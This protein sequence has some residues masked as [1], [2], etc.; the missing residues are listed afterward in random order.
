MNIFKERNTLKPYEY[1]EVMQFVDAVN[2]SYW[3]HSEVT[4]TADKQDFKV[5]LTDAEREIIQ[6]TLLAISTIEVKVKKF[7][8]NIDNYCPKPEISAVG[9]TFSESEVRHER[10][11]SELLEKL[12]LNDDFA[13]VVEIPEIKDRLAYLSKYL[14]PSYLEDQKQFTLSLALFSIFVENVSLFSQF[15]IIMSFNRFRNVMKDTSNIV[16][17]TSKEELI[18][19][20]FGIWLI[21]KIHE[22]NPD[23]FDASF[24]KRL[25][26]TAAKAIDAESKIIDW[27][28]ENHTVDFIDPQSLKEFV[29]NR[30]NDS[31]TSIGCDRLFDV[32]Q[33]QL[34]KT[35]WFNEEIYATAQTD[36]FYK[37]PTTYAKR[38]QSIDENSLF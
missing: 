1:P 13:K 31:L 9:A 7:W 3:L 30:V 14:R 32:D 12:N 23:W 17:W 24:Y 18:H 19:G 37:R 20:Q 5:N 22:E 28:F 26:N 34:K 8:G 21:N 27:I 16:E 15:A 38:V 2:H 10:A 4:F 35:A 33:E 6:K 36:F 11:Y 29:K 25:Y